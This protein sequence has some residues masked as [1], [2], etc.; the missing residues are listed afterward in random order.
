MNTLVDLLIWVYSGILC[1]KVVSDWKGSFFNRQ[2]GDTAGECLEEARREQLGCAK[3]NRALG[4]KRTAKAFLVP[5]QSLD[6]VEYIRYCRIHWIQTLDIIGY[7]SMY[8]RDVKAVIRQCGCSGYF[9]HEHFASARRHIF[10]G[11][12]PN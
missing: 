1:A 4:P 7:C 12:S 3:Q 11:R 9:E 6:T 5:L 2:S 10:A 8:Q